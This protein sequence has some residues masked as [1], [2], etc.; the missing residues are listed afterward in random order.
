MK[1]LPDALCLLLFVCLA[2]AP[3]SGAQENASPGSGAQADPSSSPAPGFSITGTVAFQ[4]KGDIYIRVVTRELFEKDRSG[5]IKQI[6]KPGPEEG[7]AGAAGFSF[8]NVPP[9]TYAIQAFQDTKKNGALDKGTFG[10]KEPWGTYREARPRFRA[11]RWDEM[12]FTL[13]RDLAEVQI[14]LR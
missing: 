4:E 7:K 1:R 10:P 2:L 12:A 8:S 13:D 11:P 14:R 5:D 9:G 6:L 3:P